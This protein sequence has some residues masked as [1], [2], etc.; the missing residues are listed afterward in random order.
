[1]AARLKLNHSGIENLLKGS[2]ADTA[3]RPKAEAAL[4]R[5]QGSA[6]VKSGAYRAS[7]HIVEVMHPTRKVFQIVADVDYAMLVEA[8][9]G[10]LARSL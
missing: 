10:N 1:M 7:L 5:A 6:P 3:C 4:A 2:A 9:T 8:D